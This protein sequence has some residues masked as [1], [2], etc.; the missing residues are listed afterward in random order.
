[1]GQGGLPAAGKAGKPDQGT[2][3]TVEAVAVGLLDAALE[4]EYVVFHIMWVNQG[5]RLGLLWLLR[6]T[7]FSF[8]ARISG[9]FLARITRFLVWGDT[10]PP[11]RLHAEAFEKG[12]YRQKYHCYGSA[13]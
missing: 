1:M 10:A 13:Y 2:S 11:F 9:F 3:V 6:M 12:N 5:V 4:G 7:D 8:L